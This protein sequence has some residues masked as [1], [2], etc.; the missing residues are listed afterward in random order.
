MLGT[1]RRGPFLALV[2]AAFCF[3]APGIVYA[4]RREFA[5]VGSLVARRMEGRTVVIV[6]V[7]GPIRMKLSEPFRSG[8]RWRFYLTLEDA[9]LSIRGAKPKRPEGVLAL[10]V[11]EVSGDVR[12]TIDVA[13]L[14]DYGARPSEEGLIVWID[15]EPRAAVNPDA[16]TPVEAPISPAPQAARSVESADSGGGGLGRMV[17]LA[18]VG[19]GLGWAV[20]H[21]RR[22]GV[23]EWGRGAAAQAGP[24]LRELVF[25]RTVQGNPAPT[26]RQSRA[27][28]MDPRGRSAEISDAFR[29]E[30]EKPASGIAALAATD[31]A[32]R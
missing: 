16:A 28:M 2:A 11:T 4:T 13:K 14:G 32:N 3:A 27:P 15:D 30:P 18:I 31:E 12:I 5:T 22:N 19:G 17:L 8:N 9:R 6:P 21:V 23:P 24:K 25:G 20:R 29:V 26:E 10:S 1:S 7:A